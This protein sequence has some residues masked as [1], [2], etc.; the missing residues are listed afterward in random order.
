MS[1]A[2]LL[3]ADNRKK[4]QAKGGQAISKKH[5]RVIYMPS[6]TDWWKDAPAL[7]WVIIKTGEV[8][9]S[10]WLEYIGKAR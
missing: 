9:I 7:A 6:S 4:R 3:A 2:G 8:K 1:I 5:P 10:R